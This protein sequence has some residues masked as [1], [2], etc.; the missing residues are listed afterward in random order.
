MSLWD[1]VVGIFKGPPSPEELA[2]E[3]RQRIIKE[4]EEIA[5]AIDQ[6]NYT[7]LEFLSLGQVNQPIRGRPNSLSYAAEKDDLRAVEILAGLGA[8]P[9]VAA[10]IGTNR[11][12]VTHKVMNG[13]Y[14]IAR[15]LIEHG[16][17]V[18]STE[19]W[20]GPLLH[21]AAK[22]ASENSEHK[23]G[24]PEFFK[25]L[26]GRKPNIAAT[27]KFGDN[28]L[29]QAMGFGLGASWFSDATVEVARTLVDSGCDPHKKTEGGATYLHYA[30]A[31]G[32][33]ELVRYFLEKGVDPNAKAQGGNTPLHWAVTH[34]RPR[35][36]VMECLL[37][38][39]ADPQ[40]KNSK[41]MTALEEVNRWLADPVIHDPRD[42]DFPLGEERF[43]YLKEMAKVLENPPPVV[44]PFDPTV[45]SGVANALRG[46]HRARGVGEEK[47]TNEAAGAGTDGEPEPRPSVGDLMKRLRVDAKPR[48][49]LQLAPGQ[50][51]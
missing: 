33:P 51:R 15:C 9:N 10:S 36:D 19:E 30:A 31:K 4:G 25:Y 18:N 40:A 8:N 47:A 23:P 44:K 34:E 24:G 1:Q 43:G 6:K 41:D 29:D 2:E 27:D 16:A 17:D 22:N 42:G 49:E 21:Y 3:K 45:A 50:W 39:G 46:M 38:A 5:Q 13:R 26:L 20:G 28:A 7:L 12:L 11:A 35:A 32:S 14:D 48:Q 37:K